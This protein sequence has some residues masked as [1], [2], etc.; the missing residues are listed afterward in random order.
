M[1]KFVNKVEDILTESLRGFG[2][3]HADLVKVHFSPTFVTR[4]GGPVKG[5]VALISR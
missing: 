5:K 1:K 3:A 4:A 2:T